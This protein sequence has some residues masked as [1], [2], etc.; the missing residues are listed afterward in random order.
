MKGITSLACACLLAVAMAAGAQST[1]TD[2]PDDMFGGNMVQSDGAGQAPA[3]GQASSPSAGPE[4]FLQSKGVDIGGYLFSDYTT[5]AFWQ[6]AYPKL[7][8]PVSGVSSSFV[9][10]L[11]AD[12]YLDARPYTFFRV[13]GKLKTVFPF[14]GSAL[15]VSQAQTSPFTPIY[16]PPPGSATAIPNVSIFELFADVNANEKVFLRLGQQVIHWGV[17]Y[18]F[19]PADILSLAPINPLQPALERQGPLALAVTVPF[20]GVDNAY[21]YVVANQAMTSAFDPSDLGVAPKVEVVL[22]NYEIGVGGYYQKNQRPK[23]MVTATGSLFGTLGVFG[24]GVLSYGSDRVLVEPSSGAPG[25][26]QSFTD[27]TTPYFSGTVGLSYGESSQHVSVVVQYYYNGQGY[28]SLSQERGAVDLLA[29]QQAALGTGTQPAGPLLST[30]DLLLPGQ[31]YL[32][33]SAA[34][35]DIR[36]SNVDLGVFFEGNLSDG[37]GVVSPYMACTPFQLF[38]VTLGPFVG[39][40]EPGSEFVSKFGYFAVSLKVT[41]GEGAF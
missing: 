7:S 25:G 10:N 34:W 1:S 28:P 5:F 19:S 29:S 30:N 14:G 18:F 26:W 6:D 4:S 2:N 27:T 17:G 11:E 20:A 3:Q 37:S 35:T 9:P 23:A 13:F 31:H 40:G 41:V 16:S 38:T 12:V 33:G 8:D 32:A 21:L 39:Y 22:G 36:A 24:E 15:G